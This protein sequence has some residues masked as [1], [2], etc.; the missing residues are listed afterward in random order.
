MFKINNYETE[1]TEYTSIK[2]WKEK[3]YNV[4][5]SKYLN[6]KTIKIKK[7]FHLGFNTYA[8]LFSSYKG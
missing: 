1:P 6:L 7:I 8:D 2:I 3:T 4:F 5:R